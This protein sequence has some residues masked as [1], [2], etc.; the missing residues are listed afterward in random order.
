MSMTGDT[1]EYWEKRGSEVGEEPNNT[2]ARQLQVAASR[3]IQFPMDLL[4]SERRIS[5]EAT[6]NKV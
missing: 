5:I 6:R 1:Q 3:D 4:Y 2:T